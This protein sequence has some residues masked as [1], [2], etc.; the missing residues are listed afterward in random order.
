MELESE[1]API[2]LDPLPNKSKIAKKRKKKS[3][4]KII[5]TKI[6]TLKSIC[7]VYDFYLIT[8][9]KRLLETTNDALPLDEI[10]KR[11]IEALKCLKDLSDGENPG[12]ISFEKNFIDFALPKTPSPKIKKLLRMKQHSSLPESPLQTKDRSITFE[13]IAALLS[14]EGIFPSAGNSNDCLEKEKTKKVIIIC[15]K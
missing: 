12:S 9:E 5:K 7:F 13:A 10:N 4:Q 1:T 6:I 3:P 11:E 14:P 15:L 8:I 2:N